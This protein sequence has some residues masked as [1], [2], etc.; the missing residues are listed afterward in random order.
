MRFYEGLRLRDALRHLDET[1]RVPFVRRFLDGD[2]L[3]DILDAI[4]AQRAPLF[5]YNALLQDD[6]QNGK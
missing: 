3:S 2:R 4:E 6:K 5:K 1:A